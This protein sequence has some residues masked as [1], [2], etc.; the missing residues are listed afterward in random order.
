[1]LLSHLW[2]AHCTTGQAVLEAGISI[3]ACKFHFVQYD[4]GAIVASN[5]ILAE[6]QKACWLAPPPS[7]RKPEHSS[8]VVK[9]AC[10]ILRLAFAHNRKKPLCLSLD[11][12]INPV[13]YRGFII[14]LCAHRSGDPGLLA[15]CPA[16]GYRS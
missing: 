10:V 6:L 7:P 14:V 12:V 1:M 5:A 13:R 9:A 15:G 8:V 16:A 2:Q 4:D 11:C 3:I